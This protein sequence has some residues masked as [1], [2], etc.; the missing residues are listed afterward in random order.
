MKKSRLK[1]SASII[2]QLFLATTRIRVPSS[3]PLDVQMIA[4]GPA[5][6]G[7]PSHVRNKLSL[8]SCNLPRDAVPKELAALFPE[9]VGAFDGIT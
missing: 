8:R 7:P 1:R 5:N 4:I 6:S 9:L 2:F 3:E